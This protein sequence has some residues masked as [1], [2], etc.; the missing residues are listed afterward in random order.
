MDFFGRAWN[1][2]FVLF[3][4]D[5]SFDREFIFYTP[6]VADGFILLSC[7]HSYMWR[8]GETLKC[9]TSRI[10]DGLETRQMR[11][12]M[13]WSIDAFFFLFEQCKTPLPAQPMSL[14]TARTE[15]FGSR[16]CKC[17]LLFSLDIVFIRDVLELYNWSQGAIEILLGFPSHV[18]VMFGW[19]LDEQEAMP[20]SPKFIFF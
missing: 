6:L 18:F 11:L 3:S 10:M 9:Y 4:V 14:P 1:W 17:H 8:N 15:T 19:W 2:Y 16:A 7:T 13:Y 5:I 12:A 20:F